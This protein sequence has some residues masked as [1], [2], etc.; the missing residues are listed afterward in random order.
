MKRYIN[1]LEFRDIKDDKLL[2]ETLNLIGV[3]IEDIDKKDVT[4][5]ID[6]DGVATITIKRKKEDIWKD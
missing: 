6:R 1:G 2:Q 4:I 5:D 3:T